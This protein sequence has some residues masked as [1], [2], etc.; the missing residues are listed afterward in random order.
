[1]PAAQLLQAALVEPVHVP[2]LRYWPAGQVAHAVHARVLI[3]PYWLAGHAATHAEPLRNVG[4]AQLVQLPAEAALHVAQLAWQGAQV[5]VP[6]SLKKPAG[7]VLRHADWYRASGAAH[8]VQLAV[9]GPVHVAH[10][11]AQAWQDPL[12]VDEQ[13]PAKYWPAG[14]DCTHWVQLFAPDDDEYVPLLHAWQLVPVPELLNVPAEQLAHCLSE[15]AVGIADTNWPA[16][17]C[18]HALHDDANPAVAVKVPALQLT[19]T[20]FC[21]PWQLPAAM[22]CPA[23]HDVHAAQ[24]WVALLP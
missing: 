9:E 4:L 16:A 19:Q 7:Q 18:R 23:L 8:A 21:A 20:A 1:M 15:V 14:H 5:L 12:V 11:A 10:D 2:L 3:S 22:A 13:A 24:V 17:H 6:T